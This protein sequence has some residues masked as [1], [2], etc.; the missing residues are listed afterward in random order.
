MKKLKSSTDHFTGR[1]RHALHHI[2]N[3]LAGL[4]QPQLIL[5][6]GSLATT[7][8]RRNL[9]AIDNNHA[10]DFR[11]SCE[12]LV[13]LPS[14]APLLSDRAGLRAVEAQLN[15][16]GNVRLMA[17]SPEGLASALQSGSHP[18]L[19][20]HGDAIVLYEKGHALQKIVQQVADGGASKGRSGNDEIASAAPRNDGSRGRNDSTAPFSPVSLS[21]GERTDPMQVV[22]SFYRQYDLPEVRTRINS[23][24]QAVAAA[25]SWPVAETGLYLDLYTSLS[26]LLAGAWLL[27]GHAA[28]SWVS[29]QLQSSGTGGLPPRSLYCPHETA[30][31]WAYFPNHLS[32]AEFCKP[33]LVFDGLFRSRALP[34]WQQELYELFSYSL[35]DCTPASVGEDRDLAAISHQL[36]RL[37]E[38]CHLLAVWHRKGGHPKPEVAGATAAPT[39]AVRP[40][41]VTS[42]L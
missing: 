19:Q 26:R 7:T 13:V 8:L 27:Q 28:P 12:L 39:A 35:T 38:A 15:R 41:P 10:T 33:S 11:L 20:L 30:D 21:A 16:L 42:V 9:S 18:R 4:L 22:L 1:E 14:G 40:A 37:A 31:A 32:R 6:L 34:E 3:R 2:K 17:L 36:H 23:W 5:Y 24:M 25:P 29:A